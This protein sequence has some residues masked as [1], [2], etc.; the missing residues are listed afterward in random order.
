MPSTSK[1]QHNLMEMVAHD[2]A[3]AKRVGIP[4]SV[5]KDFSAADKGRKFSKG[6]FMATKK[7]KFGDGGDIPDVS[8]E[9]VAERKRQQAYE[10]AYNRAMPEPDTTFGK[11]KPVPA[12]APK[13]PAPT[14]KPDERNKGKRGMKE[15]G[16]ISKGES[17][18]AREMRHSRTLSKLAK[19]EAQE[20]KT[21]SG[22]GYVRSADGIAQRGKTRGTNVAMCGGGMLKKK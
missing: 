21:Y 4:Q 16:A 7:R 20:A 22:G 2:P 13:P 15:G 6:G 9:D 8:P 3:A 10:R 14:P 11:L 12:P 18:K 17:D 5:G 1:K 19:E